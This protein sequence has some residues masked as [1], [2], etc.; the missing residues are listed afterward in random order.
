[1]ILLTFNQVSFVLIS[2]VHQSFSIPQAF[3]FLLILFIHQVSF[4]LLFLASFSILIVFAIP[5]VSSFPLITL[6]LLSSFIPTITF[7]YPPLT[8][9]LILISLIFPSLYYLLLIFIFI[10][11]LY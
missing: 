9:S 10:L 11:L 6:A 3:S 4:S 8:F 2:F 7:I 1:L 5:Q